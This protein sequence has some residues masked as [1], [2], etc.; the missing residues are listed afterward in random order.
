M[1]FTEETI[2]ALNN[3]IDEKKRAKPY[4]G[5]IVGIGLN[6][7]NS[8]SEPTIYKDNWAICELSELDRMIEELEMVRAALAE[9]VGIII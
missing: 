8:I 3:A 1:R 5:K 2:E 7:Q 4:K 6:V 9:T